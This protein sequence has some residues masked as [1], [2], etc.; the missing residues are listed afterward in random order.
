[1][2]VIA[3]VEGDAVEEGD[4]GGG[5]VWIDVFLEGFPGDGAVHGAGV[6]HDESE[7]FGELACEGAFA[8][9][10]GSVDRD[11]EVWLRGHEFGW[12]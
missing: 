8:G 7:A 1:M 5:V 4:D 6:D 12:G 10:G 2:A 9:G 3:A 11:G